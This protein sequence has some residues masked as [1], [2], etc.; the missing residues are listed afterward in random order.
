[1]SMRACVAWE[2]V[3]LSCSVG[4][5]VGSAGVQE[6]CQVPFACNFCEIFA[7]VYMSEIDL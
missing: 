5:A 7:L 1:M 3:F 2:A 6:A 4:R